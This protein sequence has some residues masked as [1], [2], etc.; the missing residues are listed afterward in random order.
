MLL[1]YMS[2]LNGLKKGRIR[3][4]IFNFMCKFLPGLI[5]DFKAQYP[6]IT[7][8]T[9]SFQIRW[10]LLRKQADHNCTDQSCESYDRLHKRP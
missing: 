10:Q 9:G 4:G 7:P 6:H 8:F 1:Q 5:Y 3:L 2:E